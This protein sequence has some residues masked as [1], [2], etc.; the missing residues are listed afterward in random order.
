MLFSEKIMKLFESIESGFV[1]IFVYLPIT[2]AIFLHKQEFFLSLF[3]IFSNILLLFTKKINFLVF[4]TCYGGLFIS[5]IFYF[6]FMFF[7]L[8]FFDRSVAIILVIFFGILFFSYLI[9]KWS[10]LIEKGFIENR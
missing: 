7:S 5:S 4:N 6:N 9:K 8:N 2:W 10:F 1:R 3:F